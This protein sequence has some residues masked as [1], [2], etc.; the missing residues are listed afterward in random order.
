MGMASPKAAFNE[1]KVAL[2]IGCLVFVLALGKMVGLDIM[3]WVVGVGM[4]VDNPLNAWKAATWKWLPGWASLLVSYAVITALMAMGIKLIKGNV[5][6][7]V[8][9]FTIIFFIARAVYIQ[10]SPAIRPSWPSCSFTRSPASPWIKVPRRAASPATY[11]WPHKL[12]MIPERTS[13]D[14]AVAIPGFPFSLNKKKRPS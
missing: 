9:G 11:P 10:R 6:N 13:P 3:G 7:F 2:L 1:D 4:W 8:R 12:P 14:P 5:A